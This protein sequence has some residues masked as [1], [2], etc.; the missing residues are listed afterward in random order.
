MKEG[1]Q[2]ISTVELSV[3][4]MIRHLQ[5]FKIFTYFRNFNSFFGEKKV[6]LIVKLGHLKHTKAKSR[7][8]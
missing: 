4:V 3:P 7:L 6:P 2:T 1:R 5:I 8:C